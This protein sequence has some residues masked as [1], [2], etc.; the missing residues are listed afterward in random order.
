MANEILVKINAD[1][2][3]FNDA[4]ESA[5]SSAEDLAKACENVGKRAGIAFAALTGA[6]TLSVKAFSEAE[7][8]SNE[9]TLALKNQGIF[10]T[11]LVESYKKYADVVSEATGIDDDAVVAAQAKLQTYIG[12]TEITQELTNALVDLSTQTGSLESAAEALGQ[13]Y[14][15]N[16]KALKFMRVEIDAN[17][18]AQER[19]QQAV[20]GVNQKV[21]GQAA[22]I[23]NTTGSTAKLVTAAGNLVEAFGKELA[24]V[25]D[26]VT[27]ALTRFLVYLKE[28][29]LL[30]KF[31]AGLTLL[32][33][34]A[35]AGVSAAAALGV[36][37]VKL[38]AAFEIAQAA[39][40]AFGG[41]TRVAVGATGIGLLLLVI[42]EIYANWN[43]II[44]KVKALFVGALEFM[45]AGAIGFGKILL[46]SLTGNFKAI[47]AGYE[48]LKAAF[49]KGKDA[50]N[51]KLQAET[52]AGKEAVKAVSE[53]EAQ[54]LAVKK[55]AADK[56][57]A[58]QERR[59]ALN[60]EQN[61]N[62]I[63]IAILQAEGGSE[64]LIKVKQTE[65]EILKQ[66]EDAKNA[67]LIAAL[68]ERL[69]IQR[70]LEADARVQS[71]EES[72]I[73]QEQILANN[74]EFAAMT[75]EQQQIFLAQN[76]AALQASVQTEQ[77]TKRKRLADDLKMQVEA[78]NRYLQKQQE[79]GTAFAEIDK[80]MNDRRVGEFRKSGNELA[81]LQ[82]SNNQTLKT[83]G[84][85]FAIQEITWKSAQS[86]MSIY[87][88]FVSALGPF[89]IP[90]GIAGAAAAL[91]F[92]AEQI[93]RVV[94]ARDGGVVPGFNR[95]GDSIPAMLQPGELIVP[96]SNFGEV[97]NAVAD[98]RVQESPA[99]SSGI[100]TG[101]GGQAVSVNIQ[102]S[103]DN[104]E[105]FLT[106]RQVE[107]RSLG[108]LRNGAA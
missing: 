45:S 58:E 34:A 5:G 29:T 14:G 33:A 16:A 105:K 19:L 75:A 20:D 25:F 81:Q 61:Q 17:A 43:T 69:E 21:G 62:A 80:V 26:E 91:A 15:G 51:V 88:G 32:A 71:L 55:A 57:Q 10:S 100:A 83:I 37:F 54:V 53:T 18:T 90:L 38:S 74:A 102:F 106:A 49:A 72:K 101:A 82:G 93:S 98:Q 48:E 70:S 76:Q 77:E 65:N 108:T 23:G 73:F 63:E 85:A 22:L 99:A 31:A 104:A 60:R 11:K 79:F 24:P 87:A 40:I 39:V 103:G 9:L 12:Q 36:A 67:D 97:V 66:L 35:A 84:K 107:A 4:M 96:R 95:G 52:G 47:I 78:N 28:N 42:Y 68:E 30:I 94:A 92:G 64:A 8:A 1:A 46:G 59:D 56:A 27:N 2:K 50:F 6:I 86:A 13:A 44:P 89:G 41:A 7:K 3:S